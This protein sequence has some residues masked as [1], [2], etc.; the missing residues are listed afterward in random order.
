MDDFLSKPVDADAARERPSSGGCR[1]GP[2]HPRP[3]AAAG[4]RVVD[5]RRRLR[6]LVDDGFDA[7][8]GAADRRP[9]RLRRRSRRWSSSAAAA[10]PRTPRRSPS[11]RTGCAGSAANVGPQRPGRRCLEL[12]LSAVD[13]DVPDAGELDELR[14]AV[15]GAVDELADASAWLR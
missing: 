14:T 1:G 13:G 12:E 15:A 11:A 5:G 4:R 9:V 6:E 7:G 2:S 8:P 3:A 10:R